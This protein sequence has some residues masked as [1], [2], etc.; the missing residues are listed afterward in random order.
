VFGGH[1]DA[2]RS[3]ATG[4]SQD[5][6]LNG[7]SQPGDAGRSDDGER[8]RGGDA[9]DGQHDGPDEQLSA[10]RTEFHS[11][12]G[13]APELK[14]LVQRPDRPGAAV[15]PVPESRNRLLSATPIPTVIDAS[16]PDLLRL[17]A[18]PALG[19]AAWRD[20]KTRRVPN[21]VWYPLVVL[22]LFLLVWD[23]AQ[24]LGATPGGLG[25][26]PGGALFALRVALSIGLVV[27]LAMGFWIIGAFGGADAKALMMLAVLFP[28]YPYY[29]VVLSSIPLD[30]LPSALALPLFEP[31]AGLFAL[32]ILANTVLAGLA[33]P[34]AL[35]VRN[36]LAGRRSWLMA[37]GR[38]VS[39]DA[40]ARTH[41]RLLERPDGVTRSGCDIDAVRMYL[42]WRGADLATLR[43]DPES[44]RRPASLPAEPAAPGDGAVRT[45]GGRDGA[46]ATDGSVDST[47]ES[48]AG[49][50]E[51]LPTTEEPVTAIDEP[52][53]PW[54]ARTFLA[55]AGSAYGTTPDQLRAALDVLTE[56][57]RET[58]W[59]SPGIPFLVPMFVGLLVSLLAGDLLVWGLTAIGLV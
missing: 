29:G 14:L 33:Y 3:S 45:D 4:R 24:Y 39:I 57:D 11:G 40:I 47:D 16:A 15:R 31:V 6:R 12:C 20:V 8:T 35:A 23:G 28:T 49:T 2:R 53:D 22:G 56:P 30:A 44:A 18:V 7:Q 27:P 26:S 54:G 19:W 32:A 9:R 13:R 10:G 46:S 58:V 34:V 48:P 41:G 38:P 37:V 21:A 55:D 17:V 5:A 1:L 43:A 52:L 50:D 51:S 25:G 59:V 42:A 36:A